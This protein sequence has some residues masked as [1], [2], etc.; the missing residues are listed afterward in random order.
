M[1]R[2]RTQ[3]SVHQYP[4]L[5]DL[6]FSGKTHA[7]SERFFGDISGLDLSLPQLR[8]L[9]DAPGIEVGDAN[10]LGKKTI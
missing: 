4:R 7:E 10:F 3:K 8:D 6:F 5:L 2:K 9:R 1:M